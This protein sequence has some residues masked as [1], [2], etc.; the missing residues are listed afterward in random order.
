MYEHLFAQGKEKNMRY[1]I[2]L[3]QGDFHFTLDKL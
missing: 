2:G 3:E 1:V